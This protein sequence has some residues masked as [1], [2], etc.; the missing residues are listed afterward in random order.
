MHG[1]SS[2]S[3]QLDALLA[4]ALQAQLMQQRRLINRIPTPQDLIE[5]SYR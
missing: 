4:S 1:S 3:G 5:F 2:S